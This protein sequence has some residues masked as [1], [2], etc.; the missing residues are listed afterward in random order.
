MWLCVAFCVAV[1]VAVAVAVWLWLCVW[2]CGCVCGCG[3]VGVSVVC[4]VCVRGVTIMFVPLQEY[5]PLMSIFLRC[6]RELPTAYTN[7]IAMSHRIDSM[8]GGIDFSTSLSP[9]VGTNDD[10]AA[11]MFVSGKALQHKVCSGRGWL[12]LCAV[13]V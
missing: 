12:G 8:T 13:W 7:E 5:L 11:K 10:V 9:V 1:C 4:I 6:L 3:R 2:L